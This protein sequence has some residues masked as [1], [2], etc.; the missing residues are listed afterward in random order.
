M[1]LPYKNICGNPIR[2]PDIQDVAIEET[3]CG[4]AHFSAGRKGMDFE[5]SKV[6]IT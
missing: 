1:L 4:T 2:H 6:V 3:H 5:P